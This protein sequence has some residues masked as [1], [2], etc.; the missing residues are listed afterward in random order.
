M[1]ISIV[2]YL[3]RKISRGVFKPGHKLPP[4]RE[5]AAEFGVNRA[6]LRQALKA[7]VVMGVLRQRVGDGTYVTARARI[8]L[9]VPRKIRQ[10]H[11]GVT[12]ADLFET[13]SIVEPE[14][15]ARATERRSHLNLARLESAIAAINSD[16]LVTVDR[17]TLVAVFV[18]TTTLFRAIAPPGDWTSPAT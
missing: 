6:S 2:R 9:S 1:T 4:E 7:L 10:R 14:L 5:L 18:A 11:Y 13:L 17:E 15:A 8:I 12:L 3:K 16:S